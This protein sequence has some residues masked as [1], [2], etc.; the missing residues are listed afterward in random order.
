MDSD[1]V[2]TVSS[3][4]S[5]YVQSPSLRHIRDSRNIHRLAREIVESLDHASSVWQKWDGPREQ[6]MKAAAPCWIPLE[7][8]RTLLN[9]LPGPT[10]TATDV[11]HHPR[12]SRIN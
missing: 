2:Y 5:D 4:L 6:L 10:L 12:Y 1:R 9:Q 7:D 3:K 8:L 11:A